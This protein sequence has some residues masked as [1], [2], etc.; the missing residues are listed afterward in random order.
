MI[1]KKREI[2]ECFLN[3][4]IQSEKYEDCCIVRDYLSTVDLT[5][6]YDVDE[7]F[8]EFDLD[9]DVDPND[10]EFYNYNDE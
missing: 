1:L 4:L 9:E 10:I 3:Q 5:D 2:W 6:V 7:D 8:S